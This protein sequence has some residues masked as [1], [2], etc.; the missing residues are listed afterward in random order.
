MTSSKV[1]SKLSCRLQSISLRLN[2]SPI[3][4]SPLQSQISTGVE[5]RGVNDAASQ[6]NCFRKV[7]VELGFGDTELGIGSARY[8]NAFIALP[9]SADLGA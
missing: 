2:K 1:L 4:L 9:V 5:L 8:L 6:C 7:E 3:S